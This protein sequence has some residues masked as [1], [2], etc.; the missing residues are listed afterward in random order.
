MFVETMLIP[1]V[2]IDSVPFITI[3]VIISPLIIYIHTVT[4]TDMDDITTSRYAE[5][6]GS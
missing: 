5:C 1:S 4:L 6:S 2:V 3:T